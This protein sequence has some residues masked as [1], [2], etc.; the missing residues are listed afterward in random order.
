MMHGYNT[1]MIIWY[2]RYSLKSMSEISLQYVVV[3]Y[4]FLVT[5]YNKFLTW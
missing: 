1:Y 3:K 2:I 5:T 4:D